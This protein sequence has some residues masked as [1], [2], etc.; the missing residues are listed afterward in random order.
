MEGVRKAMHRRTTHRWSLGLL[1]LA[2]LLLAAV[3][4]RADAPTG[5]ALMAVRSWSAPSNTRVVF[6][7]NLPVAP[8]A[9]DSGAT[10]ELVISV[11]VPGIVPA[12]GIPAVL[13]VRDSAVDS[14]FTRVDA[15]GVRIRVVFSPGLSFKGFPP[16]AA[17]R[18][19]F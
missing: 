14:V 3:V 19:P 4:V 18:R 15:N 6:D 9:P 11:P 7:F 12:D 17:Q 2:G 1:I 13:A 10:H 8:V 16:P 5:P